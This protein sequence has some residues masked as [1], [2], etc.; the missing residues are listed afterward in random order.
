MVAKAIPSPSQSCAKA[1]V[2]WT[3]YLTGAAIGALSWLVFAVA[4]APLG[5]T[6]ALTEIAGGAAVQ[7]LGA[8]QAGH[9][10]YLAKHPL[11]LDYGVLFLAGVFLG[12]LASSLASGGFRVEAVP[13]EWRRRFG[14]S[15]IKRFA[16]AFVGGV[17]VM[18]GARLANG[19]TSGNAL[20]GGLQLT[21]AGWT[22]IAVMFPSAIVAAMLIYRSR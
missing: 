9:N 6:T 14:G 15:A 7:V 13:D 3:P 18:Y 11:A 16:A 10:A 22:F 12:G 2:D 5:I 4:N 17:I 21:V 1:G 19:C 20:S 8:E